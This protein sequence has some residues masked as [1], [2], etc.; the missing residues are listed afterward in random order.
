MSEKQLHHALLKPAVL[1]ML[2]AAGFA[3]T[4][5]AVADTLTEITSRYIMLLASQAMAFAHLNHGDPIPDI[6]DTRMALMNCALLQPTQTASEEMWKELLRQ[7]IE[8][9][10][11]G[12]VLRKK[13]AE[14][15]DEEDTHEIKAFI[16][17]FDGPVYKEQMRIAGLAKENVP[18]EQVVE[19]IELVKHVDYFTALKQ[20]HS[21]TG[22]VSRFQGTV[23]GKEA[24]ARQIKIE[25]PAGLPES[26]EQWNETVKQ[27]SQKL[28]AIKEGNAYV[29]LSTETSDA[30][31]TG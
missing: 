22:E 21:K 19:G 30:A 9:I 18:S 20:K 12:S 6:T 2:R 25:G 29:A 5:P 31:M 8:E 23:L 15:R 24:E 26:I 4:R 27:R 16:N 17:W 7:P 10:P 28:D 3:G 1:Q 11:E 14:K 13:E